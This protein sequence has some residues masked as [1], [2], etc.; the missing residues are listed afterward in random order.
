M[1]HV[2]YCACCG[3][4]LVPI[5][6]EKG[7]TQVRCHWCEGVDARTIEMAKWADSPTGRPERAALHSFE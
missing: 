4:G 2:T 1:N 5:L 7:S 6:S 3:L